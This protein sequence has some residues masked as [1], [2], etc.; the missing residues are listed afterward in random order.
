[1]TYSKA[2]NHSKS[3]YGREHAEKL[4]CAKLL[5]SCC[6]SQVQCI[7]VTESVMLQYFYVRDREREM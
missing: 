6:V 3:R 5:P 2:M 4:G 7:V 1:M